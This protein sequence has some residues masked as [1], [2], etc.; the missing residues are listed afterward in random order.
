MSIGIY[1]EPI[2]NE[3][4]YLATTTPNRYRSALQSAFGG[5][6]EWVLERSDIDTLRGM[7]AVDPTFRDL[8]NALTKYNKIRVWTKS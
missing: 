5:D 1:W 2:S 6:D 7:M 4:N 8:L 3:G